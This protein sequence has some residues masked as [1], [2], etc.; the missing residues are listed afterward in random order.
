MSDAVATIDV[1]DPPE[2]ALPVTRKGLDAQA[3]R[4]F[5]ST[6]DGA[7]RAYEIQPDSVGAQAY[8]EAFQLDS[9]EAR[10]MLERK[11]L[12]KEQIYRKVAEYRRAY[13]S[14][15]ATLGDTVS[16]FKNATTGAYPAERAR[17]H[18]EI[19]DHFLSKVKSV[20][21]GQSPRFLMTGGPPGSGKS[22]MLDQAFPGWKESYV[23]LDSDEIK[24][25]L[26]KRLDNLDKLEW[27]A[28]LY[29]RECDDILAMIKQRAMAEHKNI[30][31]DGTMKSM[32]KA[33]REIESVTPLGYRVDAAY[34][35]LPIRK[36][37][38]RAIGRAFGDEARFVDPAY[39]AQHGA[40]N[41]ATFEAV[42]GRVDTWT[43]YN[44]DVPF[45]QKAKLVDFGG[46]GSV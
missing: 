46:R 25:M 20:P 34:A 2:C 37:M 3:R 8:H 38:E 5:E 35:D 30:L 11:H 1:D 16:Q 15:M 4:M 21:E 28:A 17:V 24:K 32:K 26:A 7:F 9:E 12:T 6:T 45:G 29:Q 19:V 10:A 22:S 44:T 36:S 27:R 31:F 42:K 40:A 13:E 18:Q 14:H 33:V 43:I 39:I 23:H 41:K